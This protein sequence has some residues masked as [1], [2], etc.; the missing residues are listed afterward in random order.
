M[1]S[2]GRF[3]AIKNRIAVS[4]YN[5][6]EKIPSIELL[7]GISKSY[8][9]Y[10]FKEKAVFS[11]NNHDVIGFTSINCIFSQHGDDTMRFSTYRCMDRGF[12]LPQV[13]NN[14]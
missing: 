5:A 6:L 13:K 4:D 9:E 10:Q 7:K 14:N 8:L 11:Y 2:F 3:S 12:F 1:Y